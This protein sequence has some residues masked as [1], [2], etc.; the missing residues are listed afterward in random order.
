MS[1]GC[2]THLPP[3]SIKTTTTE[4]EKTPE[5]NIS[6]SDMVNRINNM[7]DK[8]KEDFLE[9]AFTSKDF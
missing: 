4:V 6:V 9:K 2:P 7:N 5:V 3:Q 8:E 1:K